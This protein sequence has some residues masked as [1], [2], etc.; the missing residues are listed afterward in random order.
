MEIA[1][2]SSILGIVQSSS[3]SHFAPFSTIQTVK[4]DISALVRKFMSVNQIIVCNICKYCH[5]KMILRNIEDTGSYLRHKQN[6]Y[7]IL[8]RLSDFITCSAH[9]NIQS[10]K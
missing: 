1:R 5:T 7:L 10:R 2:L 9:F 8:L 4:S 6:N 3:R